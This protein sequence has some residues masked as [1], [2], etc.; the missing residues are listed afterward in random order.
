M[1]H[2]IN[3]SQLVTTCCIC[4]PEKL[5][6]Y[7]YVNNVLTQSVWLVLKRFVLRNKIGKSNNVFWHFVISWNISISAETAIDSL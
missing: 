6:S 4:W 7:S 1:S 5:I 2:D 3:V